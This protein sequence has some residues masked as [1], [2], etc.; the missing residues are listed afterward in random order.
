MNIVA[1]EQSSSVL[2]TTDRISR[3]CHIG[4]SVETY[5]LLWLEKDVHTDREKTSI[6]L[7]LRQITDQIN[8]FDDCDA[9]VDYLTDGKESEKIVLILV[10]TVMELFH[11]YM[12]FN[13]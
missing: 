1:T 2:S 10:N 8:T 4:N 12:I 3:L 9:C 5:R 11:V 6:K 13:N 7:Q